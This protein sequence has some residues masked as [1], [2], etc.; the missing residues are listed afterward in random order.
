VQGFP[1]TSVIGKGKLQLFLLA[2]RE[3]ESTRFILSWPPGEIR[4]TPT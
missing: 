2:E 4:F 1:R 3:G